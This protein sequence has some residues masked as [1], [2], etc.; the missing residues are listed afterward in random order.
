MIPG[1]T[2]GLRFCEPYP[3]STTANGRDE[4]APTSPLG[5][6]ES[7]AAR[8][9]SHLLSPPRPRVW[10]Q[11]SRAGAGSARAKRLRGRVASSHPEMARAWRALRA[12]GGGNP[13]SHPFPSAS[14]GAGG[15]E[16]ATAAA[17]DRVWKLGG[18]PSREGPAEGAQAPQ[19]ALQPGP[20][21]EGLRRA[22]GLWSWPRSELEPCAP[23]GSSGPASVC[24]FISVFLFSYVW[25]FSWGCFLEFL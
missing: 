2:G 13:P 18:K 6:R 20:D 14:R 21:P 3:A 19:P 11:P 25:V 24:C 4:S 12:A 17:R 5:R 16:R 23:R 1:G 7:W 9:V 8:G 10:K 15:A 22:P